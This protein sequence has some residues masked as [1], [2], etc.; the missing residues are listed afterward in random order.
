MRSSE[1]NHIA[2]FNLSSASNYFLLVVISSD[3]LFVAL[4][5]GAARA[6]SPIRSAQRVA[7]T[8][9]VIEFFPVCDASLG[10]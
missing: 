3:R 1:N 9:H 5:R 6:K 8:K 2:D 7:G 10:S 4:R